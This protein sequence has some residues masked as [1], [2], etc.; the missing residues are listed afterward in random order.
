V[1]VASDARTKLPASTEMGPTLGSQAVSLAIILPSRNPAGLAAFIKHV[2][3]PGDKAFRH[4]L[5]PAEF[6]ARYG[7]SL[8]DYK[9][10]AGWARAHGL[11]PGEEYS[12]HTV[13]PV[14]GSVKN[15]NAAFNV[16]LI[17]YKD[18]KGNIFYNADRAPTVP[19]AVASRV[20]SVIGFNNINRY[21]PLVRK[22]PSGTRQQTA[23]GTGSGGAYAAADLRTAYSVP[24]APPGAPGETLAVFEQGGFDP[25]DVATY[26]TANGLPK[27]Y[28]V[29]R[30]VNGYGGGID[31]PNVELEAV[32]DIDME[33]GT[34]PKLKA[35]LVYEDGQDPFGV[36]LVDSFAAIASD[37][38]AQTISVSY[39]LDEALQDPADIQAEN[40]ALMQEVAQGQTVFVSAGDRGAYGDLGNGLNAPDPGSQPLV[41]SVGG[42]TLFTGPGEI[43]LDEIT[44]NELASLGFATGGG[45]SSIWPIPSWQLVGGVSVAAAN[46][47]SS[48]YRN[49]PDIAAVGDPFTGVAVYSALNGGW[50][51]L[52]GTSV[53]SPIW[54]GY[55]SVI[56]ATSKALGLGQ[57]GFAN[58]VL[59]TLG[60]NYFAF[61][62]V[63]DGT[64][65]DALIYG[66]PGFSAGFGYD[67]VT[68]WG[69]PAFFTAVDWSLLPTFGN[70]NPPPSPNGLKG[71]A[72]KASVALSWTPAT[73]AT[74]YLV[75]GID[76]ATFASTPNVI[77]LGSKA[78]LAGLTSG[79]QYE[80]E[81]FSISPGG[82][83]ASV[84]IYLTTTN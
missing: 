79:T 45:V 36:A 78:T 27:K 7:A 14:T 83:T 25:N 52:G 73:G 37:D 30:G 21:E 76:L 28:V 82:T 39:G 60:E 17:D 23:G 64:N 31:D 12:A 35:L 71:V 1:K 69:S 58:P 32:L 26:L 59:Y 19:S 29:A 56:N 61:N 49:V 62:D 20:T 48:T 55:T 77:V 80:F 15:L 54:A 63:V 41:T 84:P 3:T 8:T 74:G 44:W 40:T 34:N 57:I 43:Y 70:T 38:K 65:G 81:V 24:T 72:G 10:I 13:L 6:A 5:T 51:Q 75:E 16:T 50:I 9:D 53:S 42:T 68:G 11:I 4:Y 2:T 66:I 47:G 67:N 33:I 46:G 22:A 18:S